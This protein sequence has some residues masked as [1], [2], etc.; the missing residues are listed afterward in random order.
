MKRI[1]KIISGVLFII[2]TINLKTYAEKKE[3]VFE[4]DERVVFLT[5]DDGPSFNNT[6]KILNILESNNVKATF[7]VIGKNAED[8]INTLKRI[9]SLNM[10]V[11]PHCYNHEYHTLYSSVEYYMDDLKKC[12][13]IIKK[14]GES[15]MRYQFVRMPGGS[16]NRVSK[17]SILKDIRR[18]LKDEGVDYIDWNVDSGDA[19]RSLV[20]QCEIEANIRKQAG[21]REA[22]VVLMHDLENKRTTTASL[23]DIINTYKKLGYK[24]KSL[25]EITDKEYLY[26]RKHNVIDKVKRNKK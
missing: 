15:D 16:D 19:S 25:N 5:F 12:T 22:E 13:D 10:A 4:L 17:S 1:V 3:Q 23:Q 2:I 9:L 26:L 18:E 21:K 24:F 6:D 8:N 11:I 7:C 20:S 14:A